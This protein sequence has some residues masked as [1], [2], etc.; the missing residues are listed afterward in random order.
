MACRDD[1]LLTSLASW[2]CVEWSFHWRPFS[3][4]HCCFWPLRSWVR[5]SGEVACA[6]VVVLEDFG[7]IERTVLR[8]AA[9]LVFVGFDEVAVANSAVDGNYYCDYVIVCDE[10]EVEHH[11]VVEGEVVAALRLEL[12]PREDLASPLRTC[13]GTAVAFPGEELRMDS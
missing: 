1:L 12:Q 13:C 10:K 6:R 8:V 5:F 11:E 3:L 9:V 7:L 2:A 4:D